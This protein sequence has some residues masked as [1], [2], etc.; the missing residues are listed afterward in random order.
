LMTPRLGPRV[1]LGVVTTNLP[2]VADPTTWNPAV[3]DFCEQ[4]QKCALICPAQAIPFEGRCQYEDGT[5]RWKI[6]PEKCYT[7]WTQIGTDCGRCMAVCPYSHADNLLHNLIRFG[8]QR[9][10]NFRRAAIW[11]DDL[12]YGKKPKPHL[13]PKWVREIQNSNSE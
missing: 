10:A 4:C 5:L 2:L 9:S 8:V 6:D 12:F 11:M 13:F 3:I 7:Y 1:R